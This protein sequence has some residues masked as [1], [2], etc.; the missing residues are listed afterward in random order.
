MCPEVLGDSNRVHKVS[1]ILAEEP[2]HICDLHLVPAP[3]LSLVVKMSANVN[4]HVLT[5]R[6]EAHVF[7][8][9]DNNDNDTR[10]TSRHHPP[11]NPEATLLLPSLVGP[12]IHM[13]PV[14]VCDRTAM[15][16]HTDPL[17]ALKRGYGCDH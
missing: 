15:H 8:T 12:L 16:I 9:S 2:W 17:R 7:R 11:N 14:P 4:M 1:D 3:Q 5:M 6:R 10:A 13:V